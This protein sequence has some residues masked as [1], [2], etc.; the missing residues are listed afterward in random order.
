MI[1]DSPATLQRRL[2][3]HSVQVPRAART[4]SRIMVVLLII[5]A[6]ALVLTPWQQ[7]IPGSGRLV[8]FD[9][10]QRLQQVQATVDGRV[11][12]WHVVEGQRVNRAGAA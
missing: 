7:N 8:A 4:L 6:F 2:A 5:T 9:P 10:S 11:D 12:R 3:L 1:P